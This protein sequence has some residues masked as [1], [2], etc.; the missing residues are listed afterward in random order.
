MSCRKLT[1]RVVG[2]AIAIGSLAPNA[3][4]QSDPATARTLFDEGRRLASNNQFEVACPKFQ[5]SYRLDPGIG[6]LFNLA[7]CWEH[8]GRT[9][10]AWAT[11]LQ[12]VDEAGRTKQMDREKIARARAT[13]LEP[14]LSRLLVKVD[15][16]DIGLELSKDGTAFGV[17]Q[18]GTALPIDP[19][20]HII[21]ARA[22]SKQTFRVRVQVPLGGQ[23]VTVVVPTLVGQAVAATPAPPSVATQPPTPIPTPSLPNS[24]PQPAQSQAAPTSPVAGNQPQSVVSLNSTETKTGDQSNHGSKSQATVGWVLGSAG[25]VGLAIGSYF[26]L[27]VNSKNKQAD[28][29]CPTS[30]QCTQQDQTNYNSAISDA[31]SDRTVSILGFALGGAALTSGAILL[32]TAPKSNTTG[33]RVAPSL[34]EVGR[35]G[36][37]LQ[38]AW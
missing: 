35:V 14:K 28:Q 13:A 36:A 6:T 16:K 7:D 22:P 34:D 12:V 19:G 8:I 31:K 4:A 25:I 17:A 20:A 38:G 18:W 5:E 1:I 32:L 37:T 3:Q 21:E 10:S 27:Q 11:F 24:E 29:V 2:L 15:S 23:T 33:F 30:V 9:A 26:G